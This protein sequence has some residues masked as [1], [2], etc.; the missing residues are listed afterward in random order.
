MRT[1]KPESFA[2]RVPESVD[3]TL[4]LLAEFAG[5]GSALPRGRSLVPSVKFRLAR[6]GLA[7]RAAAK[8]LHS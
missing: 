3:E 8:E 2:Y 7:V 5:D 6:P 1:V 4:E